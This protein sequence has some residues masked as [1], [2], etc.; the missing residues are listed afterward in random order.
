M[1]LLLLGTGNMAASHARAFQSDPRVDL[2]ACADVDVARAEKF[3]G[4]FGIKKSFGVLDKA[5][6]WGG[7]DAVS[8]VTPDRAHHP[9]TMAVL[10]AGKHVLCEKPLAENY[11]L[12]DEMTKAAE[13]AGVINMVNFTYRN[14]AALRK[15][16]AMIGAGEIGEVRHVEASYRQS[17][18]VGHHWGD[19]KTDPTWLWRLSEA[20]GSKGVLG[21]VGIH[22]LDFVTYAIGMMPVS[23][24]ARL[25]TF[26]KAEGGRIGEYTLDANDSAMLSVE[27]ANGALG[28]I[29]ASRYM[30]GYANVL[31]LDVF[32]TKGAI[33]I[34]H[35]MEWTELRAC[36]GE[37]VHTQAW[38][39]VAA[40]PVETI[41]RRFISA[42]VDGRNAEP[43]FRHA[44]ELQKILDLCFAANTAM[45][46]P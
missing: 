36:T 38:R 32:G 3:A 15:A 25:K 37:D 39:R 29:H 44:A 43:S 2:A 46:I 4:R 8:N 17:W 31:K 20:H 12:A 19:W 22:I 35:G 40:D 6:A 33:G 34:D 23:L 24:Q 27:F 7:F 11:P 14:V 45:Q 16:K 26:N 30:T 18:L 13:E 21:D 42:I 5:L 28:V 9:T 1:R 10:K 41:Y